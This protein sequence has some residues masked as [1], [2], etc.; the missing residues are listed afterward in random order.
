MLG[1]KDYM[2][3]LFSSLNEIQIWI[4]LE[5]DFINSYDDLIRKG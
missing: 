5:E 4:I 3:T 2:N 1:C